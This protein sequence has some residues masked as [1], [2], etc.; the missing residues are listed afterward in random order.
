MKR[1]LVT[2][3]SGF[4]GSAFCRELLRRGL[5]VLNVDAL[6]YAAAT[7]TTRDFDQ[8]ANYH[9]AK[10]DIRDAAAM[11]RLVEDFKPDAICN[12]AAESHV[13]RSIASPRDFLDTNV[14]GVFVL[15]EAALPYW[16]ALPAGQR[17]AFRFIQIST[18]EVFGSAE[19]GVRF[20]AETR[21]DPSSPYS[22]SKAAGDHLARAWG[23]TY[24]LPVIVTNCSNNYGPFQF[25]EKF[26]AL[27]IVNGLAGAD[28]SV[29]GDGLNIR[30]WLY[31]D[32]HARGLADAL[33]AG[34]PGATYLFGGNAERT[35]IQVAETICDTL[36]DLNR[37]NGSRRDL[38]KYVQDRPGHDR[39]YAVDVS[40]TT[41][42][43]G[44]S[45]S[46]S[47]ESGLRRT[48]DWYAANEWWWRPLEKRYD[49][50]RLGL[51]K[52]V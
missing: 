14:M 51:I 52:A 10:A 20:T 16:R 32:D 18:D 24:G 33:A 22:A 46:E 8:S 44:W 30:D 1:V 48:I 29:Y 27:T 40:A 11:A 34:R 43:L 5:T 13:D 26:V 38:I 15:L 37:P 41:A 23:R 21:Y 35:N 9:F 19:P 3:G 7:G 50:R 4:I 31:V 25:P 12:A 28:I 47:F 45:P 6:T 39:R 17:E 42:E 36:D 2:G 49:G